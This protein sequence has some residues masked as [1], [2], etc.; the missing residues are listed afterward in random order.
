MKYLTNFTT[1]Y[2]IKLS[3][4]IKIKISKIKTCFGSTKGQYAQFNFMVFNLIFKVIKTKK[5]PDTTTEYPHENICS[6][7]NK[8][9]SMK[10]SAGDSGYKTAATHNNSKDE[11][12]TAD[13]ADCCLSC[14]VSMCLCV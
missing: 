7:N 1:L 5:T 6:T 3:T 14:Q 11:S 4:D 2:H 12:V 13:I 8:L 10:P 9:S